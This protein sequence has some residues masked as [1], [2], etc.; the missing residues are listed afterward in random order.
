MNRSPRH[1]NRQTDT[2]RAAHPRS[3]RLPA[4]LVAALVC[5]A[6]LCGAA[7]SA[8]AAIFAGG[9]NFGP[10]TGG[11]ATCRSK[12]FGRTHGV[13][14]IAPSP[15]VWAHNAHAGANN[16]AAWI[17]IRAFAVN[18][19]TGATVL[20]A[21]YSS[22]VRATDVTPATWGSTSF[23][24]NGDGTYR[25]E[26]RIEW[27]N[28]TRQTAWVADRT[29]RYTLVNQYGVNMGVGGFCSYVGLMP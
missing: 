28:S 8:E 6:T 7:S 24:L 2:P 16:D 5:L 23:S 13:E 17:R 22:W 18:A 25:V 14:L 20:A 1:A 15:R 29:T 3:R 27:W 12:I 19:R 9:G 10:Y 21:G 11:N 26:T 4:V